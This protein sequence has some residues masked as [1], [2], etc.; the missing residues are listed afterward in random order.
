MELKGPGALTIDGFY[1]L[2]GCTTP[3]D[4]TNRGCSE[5]SVTKVHISVEVWT[6]GYADAWS[7]IQEEYPKKAPKNIGNMGYSGTT[8][9]YIPSAVQERAYDVEGINL[10]FYRD[11]NGSRQNPGAYFTSPGDVNVSYLW[12]CVNTSLMSNSLISSYLTLTGDS[13]GVDSA[14]VDNKTILSGKCF[15]TY[16]WYA[17]ACRAT[18]STCLTWFTGG[19]GWG[20]LEIML[21]AA[22][23]NMPLATSVG[24]S[25]GNYVSLP[26]SNNFMVY[27]WVPDPTFLRWGELV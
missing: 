11:Y 13:A 6:E 15:D 24:S 2:M 17:P 26:S 10:D 9:M 21:K 4:G 22:G 20:L 19:T 8:S 1:A 27:W 23:Y 18:P 3:L 5:S 7:Q 12:P 14:V 25:W 16:F